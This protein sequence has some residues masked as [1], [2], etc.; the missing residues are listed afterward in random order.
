LRRVL[1]FRRVPRTCAFLLLELGTLRPVPE[2]G[3]V[4]R[5]CVLRLATCAPVGP[6]AS[7][8]RNSIA[9]CARVGPSALRLDLGTL[10]PSRRAVLRL[11]PD[12]GRVPHSSTGL[13]VRLGE[14]L[15]DLQSEFG[16]VP[17]VFSG[18]GLCR[19]GALR[20]AVTVRPSAWRLHRGVLVHA[21]GAR[22]IL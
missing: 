11:V 15:C 19:W 8:L 5:V 13:L 3:L 4:P 14:A 17:C 1:E 2:L 12:F 6:S 7:R 9:T 22:C 10:V 21:G 18:C 20:L 16:Q